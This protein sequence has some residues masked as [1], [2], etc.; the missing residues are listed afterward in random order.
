MLEVAA[1]VSWLIVLAFLLLVTVPYCGL[2]LL[3]R[4]DRWAARR[5]R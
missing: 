2:W 4:L 5:G 1:S 3:D